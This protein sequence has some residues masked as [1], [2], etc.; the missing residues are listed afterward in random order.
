VF[1]GEG[2]LSLD[3]ERKAFFTALNH[4]VGLVAF[5]I[6]LSLQLQRSATFKSLHKKVVS[7]PDCHF[8]FQSKKPTF[9][10]SEL[11]SRVENSEDLKDGMQ[12]FETDQMASKCHPNIPG[13]TFNFDRGVVCA[14]HSSP[15]Q[16]NITSI[17]LKR[18]LK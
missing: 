17:R 14:C 7:Y 15:L 11:E 2:G 12:D 10:R 9:K 3:G 13:L 18:T 1:P 16:Q 4:L 5:P 8:L 6:A